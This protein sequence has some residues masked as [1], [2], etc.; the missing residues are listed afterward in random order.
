MLYILCLYTIPY[1]PNLDPLKFLIMDAL[2]VYLK[3]ELVCIKTLHKALR[4]SVKK[5]NVNKYDFMDLML[6][7]YPD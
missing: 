2:L 5:I 3:E 7:Y 6:E 1:K 4:N